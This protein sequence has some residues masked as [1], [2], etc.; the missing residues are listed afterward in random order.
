MLKG[1]PVHTIV[2]GVTVMGSGKIVGPGGHGKHL[3][4][5]IGQPPNFGKPSQP[6]AGRIWSHLSPEKS[7]AISC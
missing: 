6:S 7:L 4:R 5:R 3:W 1:W 2:R